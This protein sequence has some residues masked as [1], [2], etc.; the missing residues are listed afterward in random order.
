MRIANLS[1][2]AHVL[3]D[4]SHAVPVT[5]AT[6]GVFSGSV[7]EVF[8]RFEDFRTIVEP[9]DLSGLPAVRFGEDDLACAVPEPRQVFCVGMNYAKHIAEFGRTREALPGIFTK[10]PSCLAGPFDDVPLAGEFMDWEVEL[11]VVIGASASNVAASEAWD[12]VAGLTIG[13]DITDRPL[14]RAASGQFCLG[15]SRRGTGPVG[16]WVVTPDEFADRNRLTLGCSLDGEVMQRGTT[17]D[18]IYP[19][20]ELIELLSSVTDLLPGDLLFTGTPDGVGFGRDPQRPLRDG[21]VLESWIEGIGR[22]RNR[23]VAPLPPG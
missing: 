16:P 13:Q 21:E 12:H 9:V 5:A 10:F 14:Q 7:R 2:L 1:G 6:G 23:C 4:E 17:A 18:M 15:K 8:D 20:A 22:L 19:V 3:L 11:V